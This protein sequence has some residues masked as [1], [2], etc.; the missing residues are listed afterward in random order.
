[1]SIAKPKGR[2][3]CVDDEPNILR[4]LSW[5][6]KK[7][8]QVVTTVSAKEALELIQNDDFDVVISDQR[9][10][11][12]SGVDFLNEVRKISPRAM[13]ILLTGYSDMQTVLRS[14]NESEIFRY[15]TKPW[16]VTELPGIITQAAGIAQGHTTVAQGSSSPTNSS[17]ED[18]NTSSKTTTKLMVLDDDESIHSEVE[19][20]I[21]DL[22]EIVHFTNS[23]DAI[24]AIENGD[25]GVIVAE[26]TLGSMDLTHLLC[27]LKRQ[28]PKIVSVILT[29][30]M[31]G[32]HIAKM[33]NQGQI[34][35]FLPKPVKAGELR[36][37]LKSALAKREELIRNPSLTDRYQVQA[38]SNAESEA[39]H[40]HVLDFPK[41]GATTATK[42]LSTT[43][44]NRSF[45]GS[46]DTLIRR[47]FGG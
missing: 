25:I 34:Y 22:T 14:V 11:E 37:A 26:R 21:G 17:R 24:K 29:N 12:M 16:N 20:S 43:I 45:F 3:L 13:R 39:F 23:V 28:H 27:L 35:R 6:L 7:E 42:P 41:L 9:M 4:A 38:P 46:V 33:I 5:L 10:P 18:K 36:L 19:M 1:M 31:D 2:I 44:S 47:V 40:S 32:N 15:V 30:D 8:F